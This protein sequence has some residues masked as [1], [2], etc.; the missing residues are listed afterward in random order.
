MAEKAGIVIKTK[1]VNDRGEVSNFNFSG[2]IVKHEKISEPI[3][4]SAGHVFKMPI[5]KNN[6]FTACFNRPITP[7]EI[8]PTLIDLSNSRGGLD[9]SVFR[10]ASSEIAKSFD[11]VALRLGSSTN[12]KM[13]EEVFSLAVHMGKPFCFSSGHIFNLDL[14][15]DYGYRPQTI[16]IESL[17]GLGSS[18]GPTLNT[19]GEVI[20]LNNSIIKDPGGP[21]AFGM[22]PIDDI[23]EDLSLLSPYYPDKLLI[24]THPLANQIWFIN[25]WE[26]TNEELA[27]WYIK[28]PAEE[29]VIVGGFIHLF[30][31]AAQALQI[32]DKIISCEDKPVNTKMDAYRAVFF[33]RKKNISMVVERDGMQKNINFELINPDWFQSF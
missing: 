29:S 11:N 16:I 4:L 13:G 14:T 15:T 12:L 22:V 30:I 33:C 31:P 5:S 28:R 3:I 7:I 6:A 23:K 32:G 18:G 21:L 8:I 9:L 27:D 24:V 10:F 20:G 26:H 2:V 17:F 19:Y 25:S 1:G